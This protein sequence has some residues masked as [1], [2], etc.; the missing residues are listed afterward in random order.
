L[1]FGVEGIFPGDK[2]KEKNTIFGGGFKLGNREHTT[3]L[4][5]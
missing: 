4:L 3:P 1:Y 5:V 2:R